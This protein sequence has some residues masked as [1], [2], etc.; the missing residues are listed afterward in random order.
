MINY[1][2][3]KIV[4]QDDPVTLDQV[5]HLRENI[6]YIKYHQRNTIFSSFVPYTDQIALADGFGTPAVWFP[7]YASTALLSLHYYN[8]SGSAIDDDL[9]ITLDTQE[10]TTG[11][12]LATG[13]NN[14]TVTISIPAYLRGRW[15]QITVGGLSY[16]S[17]YWRG[18]GLYVV[19]G[20]TA[21]SVSAPGWAELADSR[22]IRQIATEMNELN[23]TPR[24]LG[25]C[26]IPYTVSGSATADTY[27]GYWLSDLAD[28]TLSEDSEYTISVR[29]IATGSESYGCAVQVDAVESSNTAATTYNAGAI[30]DGTNITLQVAAESYSKT[31]GS[32]SAIIISPYRVTGLGTKNNPEICSASVFVQAVAPSTARKQGASRT[33]CDIDYFDIRSKSFVNADQINGIAGALHNTACN[34]SADPTSCIIPDGQIYAVTTT[35][36]EIAT[37][38]L[39]CP[40]RWEVG[41]NSKG[42]ITVVCTAIVKNNEASSRIITITMQEA[43]NGETATVAETVAAGATAYISWGATWDV[44]PSTTGSGNY[45]LPVGVYVSASVAASFTIFCLTIARSPANTY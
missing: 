20:T 7:L 5:R 4:N 31:S 14:T 25:T 45:I 9:V 35:P 33:F 17:A 32:E 6:E 38:E 37:L 26:L 29:P 30:G 13:V 1:T 24:H 22:P 28:D 8:N 23:A 41:D 43:E 19:G 27:R 12:A 44:G 42:Y 39:Y 36:T 15:A 16:T 10:I 40:Y 2:K 11:I 34:I 3:V 18:V 21:G